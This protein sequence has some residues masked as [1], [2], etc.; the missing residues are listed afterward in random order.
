MSARLLTSISALLRRIYQQH[1]ET[2]IAFYRLIR[3]IY[4]R[5]S[6][7]IACSFV[8]KRTIFGIFF[9]YVFSAILF[10]VMIVKFNLLGES[11][12]MPIH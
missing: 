7:L 2:Q 12:Q 8:K 9:A 3:T 1:N 6:R 4:R 10:N 5:L 11:V